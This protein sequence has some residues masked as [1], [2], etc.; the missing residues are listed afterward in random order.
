LQGAQVNVQIN[1][2]GAGETKEEVLARLFPTVTAVEV[3][4]VI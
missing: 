3:S 2:Y 1:N 4:D